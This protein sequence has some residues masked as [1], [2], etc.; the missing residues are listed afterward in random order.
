MDDFIVWIIILCFIVVIPVTAI[1]RG[2]KDSDLR[3][4]SKCLEQ[5]IDKPVC[6]DLYIKPWSE[7][8]N[9]QK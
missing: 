2:N 5:R 1:M 9:E 8:K 3:S 4:Y 6:Y 7:E